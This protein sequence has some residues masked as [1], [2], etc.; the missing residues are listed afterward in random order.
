MKT[1]AAWGG[2]TLDD[3]NLELHWHAD[4]GPWVGYDVDLE[5][6]RTSA[7]TLDWIAQVAQKTWATP[8]VIGSLVEA[9]VACLDP[10]A[11]LCSLGEERGPVVVTK[12]GVRSRALA[13]L[14]GRAVRQRLE[15]DSSAHKVGDV[16]RWRIEE[17]TAIARR[18][19]WDEDEAP[20]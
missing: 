3:E 12:A 2:W 5:R 15:G 17:R 13:D 18:L 1:V 9:L 7:E 14:A 19:G 11:T 4:E 6:C 10:Q 20:A 8:E 16:M